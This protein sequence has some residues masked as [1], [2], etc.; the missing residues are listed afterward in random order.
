MVIKIIKETYIDK[1]K[2]RLDKIKSRV[3]KLED[4]VEESI[5]NKL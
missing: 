3:L 2:C 1:L 4:T 5:Q